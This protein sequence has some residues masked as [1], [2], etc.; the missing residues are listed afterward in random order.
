MRERIRFYDDRV[1]ES[2]A[3]L[4]DELEAETLDRE[5][6]Q[7][8]KLD[9]IGRLVDHKR[10]ELAETFFNSV[11]RRVLHSTYSRNEFIFVRSAVSTEYIE[12]SPPTYRSY[13][14]QET[15]LRATFASIFR[16]FGWTRPYADLDRDVDHV[17]EALLEHLGGSWPQEEPNF[18][19]QVLSSAFYRNRAAY[20]V[21]RIVNGNDQTPFVVPVLHDDDG[22]LALDAILL[23]PDEHQRRVL[24]LAG[25]LPR[26]HGRAV[27]LRGVPPVA[28]A[29]EA[30]VGD[31]HLARARRAGQDALLPRPA[32]PPP[33]L[34]RPLRRGPRRA[35]PG[36]ARLLPALVPVRVQGDQGRLR[37]GQA[38]HEPRGGEAE[39]HDGEGGRPRR[40]DG[41][42]ARVRGPRAPAR[43]LRARAARR[44]RGP[45]AVDDRPGRRPPDRPALLRRAPDDAARHLPQAGDAPSSSSTRCASSATPSAS[46]PT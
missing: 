40:A 32:A 10:P 34:A 17:M 45:R 24:A 33:S 20:V 9:Y 7:E 14:P 11:V 13:Y 35:G 18:Q 28:D 25:L 31:L 1:E 46:S 23:D 39:V 4:R 26:R 22:R 27:G 21:G 41:R 43:P 29:D 19:V 42:R 44:P 15:G 5:T 2:V 8:A 38:A 3:R 12:S 30:A 36:D 16:D 6:W 37:A